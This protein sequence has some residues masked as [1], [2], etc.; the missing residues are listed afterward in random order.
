MKKKRQLAVIYFDSSKILFYSK[1]LK[2]DLQIHLSSEVI[3]DL[4]VVDSDKL[5]SLIDSF[6]QNNNLNQMEFDCIL[7]FSPNTTFD[8]ELAEGDSKFKYEE[9]QKFLDIVPFEDTLNNSYNIG[10]KTRVVAVNKSLFDKL[11][12]DF[13]NNKVFISL[14][15]PMSILTIVYPE[16]SNNVNLSSIA[17]KLEAIKQY[18]LVGFS[19]TY[20][21]GEVKT[22]V[23]IKRKDI[24]LFVLLGLLAILFL[25]LIYMV[26]TTFLVPKPR[27]KV[28]NLPVKTK[29]LTSPD[30]TE[31]NLASPSSNISTPSS[32]IKT[33]PL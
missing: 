12:I 23:G 2:T 30:K 32:S 4:E 26:Y 14:V 19:E 27:P 8:K 25:V 13:E 9:T 17:S 29:P 31:N 15:V 3:S 5:S 10:K 16:F 21:Q 33:Q 6:F 28:P 24:R 22:S 7:V 20:L 18:S 11:R 1:D